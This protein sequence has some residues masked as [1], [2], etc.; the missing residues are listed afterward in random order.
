MSSIWVASKIKN[1]PK[2]LRLAIMNQPPIS[3]LLNYFAFFAPKKGLN[4]A[5]RYFV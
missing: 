2:S 3:S 4:Q 5:N 1:S